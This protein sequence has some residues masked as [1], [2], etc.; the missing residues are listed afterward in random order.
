MQGLPEEF[1]VLLH[2]IFDIKDDEEHR[3]QIIINLLESAK[4]KATNDNS[5][6]KLFSFRQFINEK[7]LKYKTNIL[8]DKSDEEVKKFFGDIPTNKESLLD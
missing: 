7:F 3:Y 4:E 5:K 6:S 1:I 8:F 2:N